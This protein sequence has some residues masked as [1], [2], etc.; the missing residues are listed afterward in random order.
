MHDFDR[1]QVN[2]RPS[3]YNYGA[4]RGLAEAIGRPIICQ[5]RDQYM[6]PDQD[7]RLQFLY[8]RSGGR[9]VP[10]KRLPKWH[11]SNGFVGYA[12]GIGPGNVIDV[13]KGITA[14]DFWID[15]ESGVRTDDWFDLDKVEDVC[16]Q[17]YG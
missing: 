16:R 10:P 13:L 11:E 17:V 5:H 2:F 8:D 12:G 7:P 1:I 14:E 15:M 9:G 6:F 3:W 4:L